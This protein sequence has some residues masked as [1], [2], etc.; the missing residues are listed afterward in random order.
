MVVLIILITTGI[1]LISMNN[2][3]SN[4]VNK[5]LPFFQRNNKTPQTLPKPLN[6]PVE[7]KKLDRVKDIV[8]KLEKEDTS[9]PLTV[10]NIENAK[11]VLAEKIDEKK[12]KVDLKIQATE[13]EKIEYEKKARI[14]AE[15]IAEKK[16]QVDLKIQV[17]ER[18]KIEHEK[19]ARILADEIAEKKRQVDLKM[20]AAEQ[21]KIEHEKKA[22][23]LA[24]EIAEK[25]RKFDLKIRAAKKSAEQ[26]KKDREDRAAA[27]RAKMV[28]YKEGSLVVEVEVVEPTKEDKYARALEIAL[29]NKAVRL[30]AEAEMKRLLDARRK[31]N[32]ELSEKERA[33][34]DAAEED[35]QAV[36]DENDRIIEEAAR[37]QREVDE[38]VRVATQA[39]FDEEYQALLVEMEAEKLVEDE[40]L[41]GIERDRIRAIANA[42]KELIEAEQEQINMDQ[43]ITDQVDD[44]RLEIERLQAVAQ[45]AQDEYINNQ[46]VYDELIRQEADA[47]AQF[48]ID[49]Y[50]ETRVAFAS[51]LYRKVKNTMILPAVFGGVPESLQGKILVNSTDGR[52]VSHLTNGSDRLKLSRVDHDAVS[53][54]EETGDIP[55]KTSIDRCR[56]TCDK[57][58]RCEGFS[59]ERRTDK[60]QLFSRYAEQ[61]EEVSPRYDMYYKSYKRT[62]AEERVENAANRAIENRRAE[63]A[64]MMYDEKMRMAPILAANRAVALE[65]LKLQKAA[66]T[67]LFEKRKQDQLD[68]MEKL[69]AEQ[70]EA[71]RLRIEETIRNSSNRCGPTQPLAFATEGRKCTVVGDC[72]GVIGDVHGRCGSSSMHCDN[73]QFWSNQY[74]YDGPTPQKPDD[75]PSP[76]K[77]VVVP[78]PIP[79]TQY[80]KVENTRIRVPQQFINPTQYGKT[81]IN[82]S[83]GSFV[84]VK[85]RA[86]HKLTEVDKG[87][88]DVCMETCN[89]FDKCE[90]FV[91]E[92]STDKCFLRSGHAKQLEDHGVDGYDMYYKYRDG[93]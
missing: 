38:A 23:I 65:K 90:G 77:D 10:V 1:I 11:K 2:K 37:K 72:C 28:K 40:R 61:L 18:E 48:M 27:F 49:S 9:S 45:V 74:K 46:I 69:K 70:E 85:G 66:E 30:K 15:E 19:K 36:I 32:E 57:F 34:M 71:Q 4:I 68:I 93:V 56:E 60:C 47:N 16:R 75:D 87:S 22:R 3:S 21:E 58:D 80:R 54:V 39:K 13:Q 59:H 8:D 67:A 33:N 42:E 89:S 83:D 35:R 81:S 92:R 25:K 76:I 20:Q 63:M 62:T 64:Q 44:M 29:K 52:F 91:H 50:T 24:E 88:V 12:R 84:T 5:P 6:I 55:F 79:V 82:A 53:E 51:M 78:I 86:S 41:A 73:R 43:S 7:T 14:L 26:A 31:L 17:A